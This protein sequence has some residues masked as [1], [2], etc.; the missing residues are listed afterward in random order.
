M[1]VMQCNDNDHDDNGNDSDN[2]DGN[3]I[4]H[5]LFVQIESLSI[6]T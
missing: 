3:A 6:K 5:Q 4:Y 1:M 2:N